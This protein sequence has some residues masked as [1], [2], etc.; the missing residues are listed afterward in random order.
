MSEPYATVREFMGGC[1]GQRVV[2]ITQHD[3]DEFREEGLSFV[4][5]H[6]EDGTT[7][8][9]NVGDDGTIVVDAGES[10]TGR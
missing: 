5:L 2:D 10:E 9:F 6:F 1:I 8:T 4:S 3:E 7:V